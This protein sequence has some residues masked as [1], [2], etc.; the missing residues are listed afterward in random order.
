MDG[1]VG[2]N[3][4][5]CAKK[6]KGAGRSA[7]GGG[8]PEE[9][10]APR[11]HRIYPVER[12]WAEW[13]YSAA[14]PDRGGK[15]GAGPADAGRL[16]NWLCRLFRPAR[17]G[18]LFFAAAVPKIGPP[19]GPLSDRARP[20]I[21]RFEGEEISGRNRKPP[22]IASAEMAKAKECND[23]AAARPRLFFPR[24]KGD[25][26]TPIP[27]T[28]KIRAVSMR[29]SARFPVRSSA[30]TRGRR[31]LGNWFRRMPSGRRNAIRKI[32]SKKRLSA[33]ASISPA[34]DRPRSS[35]GS[36]RKIAIEIRQDFF[37]HAGRSP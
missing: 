30:K 21:R 16:G 24:G 25:D 29:I 34:R 35:I 11:R 17:A 26:V 23:P 14:L 13:E 28:K 3:G 1:A 15:E 6:G 7:F 5:A 31:S 10:Y 18:A 33:E 4:G 8:V 36:P 20:A 37:R 19:N 9:P 27:G 32:R 2:G 12:R 22:S